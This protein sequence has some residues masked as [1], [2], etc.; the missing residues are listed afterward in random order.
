MDYK[1]VTKYFGGVT[2]TARILGVTR[3]AVY[4]WRDRGIPD[5]QKRWIYSITKGRIPYKLLCVICGSPVPGGR[6]FSTSECITCAAARA[7]VM[8][9]RRNGASLIVKKAVQ[10]GKLKDPKTLKCA[11]C[12]KPA[13]CY[14]HR[15]YR[16]PLEVDPICNSCNC[17][18]GTG[19]PMPTEETIVKRIKKLRG[20]KK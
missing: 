2:H 11:D 9:K 8:T 20:I 13:T 4:Y 7:T 6:G 12:G 16:K 19:L 17:L 3:Q 14:E 5:S 18:R 10:S 15:D 1:T